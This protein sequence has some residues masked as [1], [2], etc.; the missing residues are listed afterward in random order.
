MKFLRN[1]CNLCSVTNFCVSIKLNILTIN[2]INLNSMIV[3]MGLPTLYQYRSSAMIQTESISALGKNT[4]C[5][6][7]VHYVQQCLHVVKCCRK[8]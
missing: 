7:G 6:H 5:T 4:N 2:A 8:V 1:A 3:H